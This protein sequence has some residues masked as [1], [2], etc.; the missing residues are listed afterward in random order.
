MSG[1][2]PTPAVRVSALLFSVA[3]VGG[4]LGFTWEHATYEATREGPDVEEGLRSEDALALPGRGRRSPLEEAVLQRALSHFPPY[5]R[6]N[7]PEVLAADYL[8][9]GAPISV[10]WLST[11]DSSDQVLEH[12]RKALA[13]QG[14]PAIGLRYNANA[15][16]VGYWSLS[17]KEVYLVSTLAQQGETLVF[18]SAGQVGSLA[19]GLGRV[20][21]WIPLPPRLEQRVGLSFTLEG[22]TQH[23]V[24][25]VVS[26]SSWEKVADAYRAVLVGQGWSI[27][28]TRQLAGGGAE[29]TLRRGSIQGTVSLQ[30]D[31][32]ASGVQLF[33]SFLEQP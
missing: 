27:E 23:M 21:A 14:L 25:G 13:E 9:S 12:Y 4:L 18:V 28:A 15:G 10:A 6:G 1:S 22:T 29:L 3:V 16:F 17:S 20:P 31:L 8:G 32:S 5:P 2:G 26:E 30:R 11:S 7:R 24:S 33:L 19:E